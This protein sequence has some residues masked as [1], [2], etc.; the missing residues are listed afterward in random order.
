M[1]HT[2]AFYNHGGS[3][4]H[5][6]RPGI[7]T[8]QSA[9]QSLA[10]S[11]VQAQVIPKRGLQLRDKPALR[12]G[13]GVQ[14]QIIPDRGLQLKLVLCCC[15][16]RGR[17]NTDNPRLGFAMACN[18]FCLFWRSLRSNPDNPHIGIATRVAR[19]STPLAR[20]QVRFQS[21]IIPTRGLQ[22]LYFCDA[23]DL[24]ADVQV[25]IIPDRGLQ[26]I[27]PSVA[28]SPQEPFKHT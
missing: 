17:S 13:V 20:S 19:A 7:A 8:H 14:T 26:P 4:A 2:T 10:S 28:D 25:Q 22:S 11:G 15:Q 24:T 27:G 3:N 5:N 9:G 1:Q 16:L 23:L 12:L 21:Q 18:W 6:P